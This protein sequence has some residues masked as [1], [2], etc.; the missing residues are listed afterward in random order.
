MDHVVEV[1]DGHLLLPPG[2]DDNDPAQTGMWIS[3]YMASGDWAMIRDCP[4]RGPT[5]WT[6][7]LPA[8]PSGSRPTPWWKPSSDRP[9]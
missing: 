7:R 9:R 6:G 5:H 8:A 1:G 3:F 2:L 4:P